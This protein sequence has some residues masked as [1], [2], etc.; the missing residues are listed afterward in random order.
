MKYKSYKYVIV[1]DKDER[2]MAWG[3]EQLCYCDNER[4]EDDIFPIKVITKQTA[5][6][7]I[8]RSIVYRKGRRFEPMT[9]REDY[10]LMPIKK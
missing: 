2:P 4:W 1:A 8:K 9:K 6:K 5:E 7:Q 10:L 3:D